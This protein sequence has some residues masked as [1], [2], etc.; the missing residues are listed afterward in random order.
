MNLRDKLNNAS[1]AVKS[2]IIVA[3]VVV[4]GLSLWASLSSGRPPNATRAYYSSDDGKTFF[5]DDFFRSYPFDHDGKPAY[6]AYV[7]ETAKGTKFVGY[8][9]RYRD[10]GVKALDSLLAQN[11]MT[12]EQLRDAIQ[13]LRSQYTEVKKPN[14]P[15][16]KWYR[17][18]SSQ[19]ASVEAVTSPNG[20]DDNLMLVFP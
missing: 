17:A 8:L 15:K 9:E 6:R 16:A 4:V 1:P 10:D 3:F 19:A 12:Q 18:G 11:R 5:V 20:P 13:P 7:Y 14:N 2:G